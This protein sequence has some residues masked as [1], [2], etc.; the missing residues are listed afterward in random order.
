MPSNKIEIFEKFRTRLINDNRCEIVQAL[1]KNK[2][3][4]TQIQFNLSKYLKRKRKIST[5]RRRELSRR[6]RKKNRDRERN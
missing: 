5:N 6:A 4:K 3:P 2:E 1:P